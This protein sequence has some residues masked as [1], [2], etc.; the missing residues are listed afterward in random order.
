MDYQ[1]YLDSLRGKRIGVIGFGV[2]WRVGLC[3]VGAF[4]LGA[5]L[6]KKVSFGSMMG[7]ITITVSTLLLGLSAPRIMLAVFSMTLV[8]WRHRSNIKRLLAGTEPDFK[9]H[10]KEKTK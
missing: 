10:K 8:I 1:S 9:A 5:L 2:D 7:A 3:V 4:L 6:S